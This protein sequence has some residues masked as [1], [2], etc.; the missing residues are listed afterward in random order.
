MVHKK[1]IFLDLDNTIL[2]SKGAYN[3]SLD[4]LSHH[5]KKYYGGTNFLQQ[6]EEKKKM[7]K[8][9]LTGLPY[10]RSRI[11]VFKELI[12]EKEHSLN[13]E[14]ILYFER[15]YFQYFVE[16]MKSFKRINKKKY[17]KLF[18]QL[19]EYSRT[20]KIFLLTNESLKTQLIKTKNL[21]PPTLN[22]HLI[23]SEEV[24]QEKPSTEYFSFVLQKADAEAKDTIMIGDSFEDDICGALHS[25]IE[26]I[27][28]LSVF[29]EDYKEEKTHDGQKY[30][31]FGNVLQA[32]EDLE[33]S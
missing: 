1:A 24:G 7:V 22:L 17:K 31:I 21:L 18:S 20:K 4:K 28:I 11:L 12:D 8:Q 13:S 6:F 27:Q 10:H 14:K 16:Y 19:D 3:Y 5:W 9:R 30:K 33:V 26:A 25:G 23:T 29:G 15:K 2:D 32:L